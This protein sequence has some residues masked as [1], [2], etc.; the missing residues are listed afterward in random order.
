MTPPPG[1]TFDPEELDD[2]VDSESESLAQGNWGH[3]LMIK[4]KL[5]P[6]TPIMCRDEQDEVIFES[7]GKFFLYNQIGG[8]LFE[9]AG[10]KAA[11][12]SL[13]EMI[14]VMKGERRARGLRWKSYRPVDPPPGWT[15]DLEELDYEG[16]WVAEDG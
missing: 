14:A 6:C 16:D 8:G 5:G 12:S 3:N 1:W 13:D 10:P 4:N 15:Y 7:S 9:L 2:C 11:L